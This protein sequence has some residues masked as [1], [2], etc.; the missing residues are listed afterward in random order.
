MSV[1]VRPVSEVGVFSECG[2]APCLVSV[3]VY[4]ECLGAPCLVSVRVRPV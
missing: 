4:S 1:G 3:G 2:G